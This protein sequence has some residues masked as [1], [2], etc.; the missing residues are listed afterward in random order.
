[1]LAQ[2]GNT[3]LTDVG[4]EVAYFYGLQADGVFHNQGEIDAYKNT[5][6]TLIQPNAKPGDVKYQ[7]VN[8][9]GK[10]DPTDRT[11]LGS[12][13]SSFSYG[14]S[15]NLTYSG[16]DLQILFYGVQGAEGYQRPGV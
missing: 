10:I 1:M 13:T 9:D 2:F 14:A 3:T 6:G 7:D 5:T 16:F 15:L 11:Y 12:A 8:G 4:R